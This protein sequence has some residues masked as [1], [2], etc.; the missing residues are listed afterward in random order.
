MARGGKRQG[1]PGAGYS[2]RTDLLTNRAP[3]APTPPAP[4]AVQAPDASGA[5]YLTPDQTPFPTDPSQRPGEPVTAGLSAA[6]PGMPEV[7]DDAYVLVQALM[8]HSPNPDL[9]RLL[10]RMD[11]R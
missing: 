3:V 10:A 9:A 5:P 8:M 1:T 2:N 7:R 11:Y 4:S 6:M